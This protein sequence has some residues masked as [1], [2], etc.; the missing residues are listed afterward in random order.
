MF[1]CGARSN[2]R[3]SSEVQGC[4]DVVRLLAAGHQTELLSSRRNLRGPTGT[5]TRVLALPIWQM[6]CLRFRY[7]HVDDDSAV[8]EVITDMLKDLDCE[9]ISR[10]TVWMP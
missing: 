10:G 2:V 9:V 4:F 1:L 8:L 5:T 7:E 6:I 3:F